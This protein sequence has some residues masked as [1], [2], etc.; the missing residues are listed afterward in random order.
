MSD[1]KKDL[2]P[3]PTYEAPRVE[4]IETA[5]SPSATAAGSSVPA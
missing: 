3:E 2:T 4:D 1:E 5:E